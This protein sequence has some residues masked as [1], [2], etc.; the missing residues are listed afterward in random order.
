MR[1]S[2]QQIEAAFHQG[3]DSVVALVDGL[4]DGVELLQNRLALQE[5]QLR[6][7]QL[8]V[9]ALERRIE[10]LEARLNQNSQ[11][12]SS[13]PSRDTWRKAFTKRAKASKPK[14]G[15]AGHQGHSLE[16]VASPDEVLEHEPVLCQHCGADLRLARARGY[17][18]RQV[19]DLPP[20]RLQVSAHR[21]IEKRCEACGHLSRGLFPD[22]VKAPVQYGAR[23]KAHLLYLSAY[24]LIPYDRLSQLI[25]DCFGHRISPGTL[26]ELAEQAGEA[27]SG[28]CQ[29]IE[30]LVAKSALVHA[31]ETSLR[32][33]G[34]LHYVHVASTETLTVYGLTSSRGKAAMDALGV[35]PQV[36]GTM[37]HDGWQ[38]Y[39]HYTGCRHALCN[40]HHL[41]ELK[42]LEEQGVV[43]ARRMAKLLLEMKGVV[44]AA[45]AQGRAKPEADQIQALVARYEQ[46]LERAWKQVGAPPQ[47]M[48]RRLLADGSVEIQFRQVKKKSKSYNLL[49]RLSERRDQ[50]LRFLMEAWVPFDNNQAE[51]DLRMTKLKQKISG[52]FRSLEGGEAFCRLRSY[53]STMRKQG[54]NVL[55]ALQAAVEG[56]PLSCIST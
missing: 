22:Q 19:F 25:A 4:Q 38:S 46:E 28:P 33:A 42:A 6:H 29:E 15:Q 18:R 13:P 36:T 55:M 34:K 24:Q 54:Q 49:K 41:R 44:D 56:D 26:A 50:V 11:N 52:C 31:D 48:V 32:V 45:R 14:G 40:A 43:W 47:E 39:Q 30:R 27:L 21:A 10:D 7:V 9:A 53:V 5:D 17:Q 2:R 35:L 1:L 37:I 23:L 8:Y 3:L 51:R 16:M 12:S 20:F